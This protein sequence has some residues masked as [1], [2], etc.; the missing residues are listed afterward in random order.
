MAE[1]LN[2]KIHMHICIHIE[3]LNMLNYKHEYFLKSDHT[4]TH[5]Q[6][7]VTKFV[8]PAGSKGKI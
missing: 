1:I 7:F 3:I 4:N 6:Q 8:W 5:K 2:L